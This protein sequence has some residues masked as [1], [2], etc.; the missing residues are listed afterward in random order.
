MYA[1]RSYYA[2]Y[3][4]TH[5][6][7]RELLP[8]ELAELAIRAYG[9]TPAGNFEGVI[10]SYSIHYTKLYDGTFANQANLRRMAE[11]FTSEGVNVAEEP[12]EVKRTI[13]LVRFGGFPGQAA[14]NEMATKA[15]RAGIAAEVINKYRITSYN[16][17][18]TKLLR[19]L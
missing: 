2:F 13:S 12:V 15:R 5:E 14:A 7:V 19:P 18:Y 10:T 9:I 4:W 3:L 6:Q 8:D 11:R 16:V 1:I 17:C